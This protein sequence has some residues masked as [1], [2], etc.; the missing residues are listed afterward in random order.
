MRVTHFPIGAGVLGELP[1]EAVVGACVL[2]LVESLEHSSHVGIEVA[3]DDHV[4]REVTFS[5]VPLFSVPVAVSWTLVPAGVLAGEG[6]S[7]ID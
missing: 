3:D 6:D 4:T 5:V 1:Y 2:G 7:A